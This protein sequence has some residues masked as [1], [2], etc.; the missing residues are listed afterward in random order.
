[1]LAC[2]IDRLDIVTLLVGV[3]DCNAQNKHFITALMYAS[4]Y[5]RQDIVTVLMPY[6]NAE[7][8]NAYGETAV[9]VAIAVQEKSERNYDCWM[10][11]R[12]HVPETE[13]SSL[14]KVYK[15]YKPMKGD[16][17][18]VF[19]DSKINLNVQDHFGRTPFF[20]ACSECG[21]STN[22]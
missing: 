17:I 20:L 13:V 11:F 15:T 18:R 1:M 21:D 9:H 19:I 6:S 14:N 3:A 12:G 4:F 22:T 10:R 8:K 7:L 16:I 2:Y 5:G